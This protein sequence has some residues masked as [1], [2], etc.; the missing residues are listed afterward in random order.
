ML[1]SPDAVLYESIGGGW[2][3][4]S[5][6][7]VLVLISQS[8]D[9]LGSSIGRSPASG[10]LALNI[11]LS[12]D[13]SPITALLSTVSWAAPVATTMNLSQLKSFI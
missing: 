2:M 4:S 11:R 6:C 3:Y 12:D 5:S 9:S 1:D 8:F 7:G 13:R 10:L